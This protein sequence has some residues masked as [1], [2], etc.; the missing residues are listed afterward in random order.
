MVAQ[1]SYVAGVAGEAKAPAV[2][3]APAGADIDTWR[4]AMQFDATRLYRVKAVAEAL[5]VSPATIYRAVETGRLAG[6][7]IG[8]GKG[9]IRIPG[10]AIPAYLEGCAR[11]ATV[12]ADVVAD[13][14]ACVVCGADFVRTGVSHGPADWNGCWSFLPIRGRPTRWQPDAGRCSG[15]DDGSDVVGRYRGCVVVGL[16]WHGRGRLG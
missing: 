11:T 8:E 10:S 4:A 15:V 1:A 7:K 5:D 14:R 16:A 12:Q 3:A 2:L 13:G 6:Y 9:A